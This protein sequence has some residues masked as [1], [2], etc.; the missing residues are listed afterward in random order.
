MQDQI[1]LALTDANTVLP[2]PSWLIAPLYSGR[3][4]ILLSPA[5][6]IVEFGDGTNWYAV[7]PSASTIT[8]APYRVTYATRPRFIRMKI[9]EAAETIILTFMES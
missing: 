6:G 4:A 7:E 5:V 1:S 8:A 2:L 9:G 3:W